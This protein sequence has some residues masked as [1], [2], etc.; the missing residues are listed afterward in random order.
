MPRKGEIIQ[1]LIEASK[2]RRQLRYA[3][4]AKR[5]DLAFQAIDNI[6]ALHEKALRAFVKNAP[7]RRGVGRRESARPAATAATSSPPND[8]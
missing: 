5:P 3:A 6:F 7:R 1:S 4:K 8:P 2:W